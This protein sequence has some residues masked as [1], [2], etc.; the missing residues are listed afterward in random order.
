[1]SRERYH[2]DKNYRK[3]TL[4][5]ANKRYQEDAEYRAATIKRAL[6]RYYRLKKTGENLKT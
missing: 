4:E 3:A 2:K 1:M 5:R 6:E